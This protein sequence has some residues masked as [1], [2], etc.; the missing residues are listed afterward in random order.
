MNKL[1]NDLIIPRRILFY[2]NVK[3]KRMFSIQKFYRT[4]ICILRD[5]GYRVK[6]SN[7][8]TDYLCFWKYDIAF[9]YF[10]RI[11]LIPAVISRL[12]FKKVVFTGGIDFLDRKYAGLKSYIIQILFFKLCVL[13]S[14]KNILVSNSDVKNIKKIKSNLPQNFFLSYHVIDFIKYEHHD[15]ALREKILCTIAWM[16][17]EENVIRKGV[18]K[19]L[20]LFK[21][22]IKIDSDYR[23]IIIGPKGK[24][25]LLIEKIIKDQGLEGLVILTGEICEK[26]KIEILK[27][28]VIYSQL[29]IYEGF[30]I[31]A[32]EGLAAGNIVVHTGNGGLADGI[33]TNGVRVDNENFEEIVERIFDIISDDIRHKDMVERGIIHVSQNFIYSRRL[34]AFRKIFKSMDK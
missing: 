3:T 24:G 7:S 34:E 17:N 6:L 12:F 1:K 16:I 26:D 33:A 27:K 23:M 29:S 9:I 10:Y 11:G 2:S 13:F 19:S 31:A 21:E 8:F 22:I 20:L 14:N 15:I 25:S 18:D 5:L 28:S 30:G 4:D 32:V